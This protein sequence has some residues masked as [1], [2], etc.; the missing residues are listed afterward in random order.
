MNQKGNKQENITNIKG[1]WYVPVVPENINEK[2]KTKL[3]KRSNKKPDNMDSDNIMSGEEGNFFCCIEINDEKEE[4]DDYLASLISELYYIKSV[5]KYKQK[6]ELKEYNCI[7]KIQNNS[8]FESIL[9]KLNHIEQKHDDIVFIK[10]LYFKGVYYLNKLTDSPLQSNMIEVRKYIKFIHDYTQ[11]YFRD[12]NRNKDE[13]LYINMIIKEW[14]YIYI[15]L[16]EKGVEEVIKEDLRGSLFSNFSL[17]KKLL[18]NIWTMIFYVELES[19]RDNILGGI[20]DIRKDIW[21]HGVRAVDCILC[22]IQR[23]CLMCYNLSNGKYKEM[24]K[25]TERIR[26]FKRTL[27]KN[28]MLK[29]EYCARKAKRCYSQMWID[30]EATQYFALSGAPNKKNITKYYEIAE[31]LLNMNQTHSKYRPAFFVKEMRYYYKDRLDGYITYSE[32]E[33]KKQLKDINDRDINMMFSCC[34]RKLLIEIDKRKDYP[35]LQG[36]IVHICIKYEPCQIC[37]R[38]L[39][40]YAGAGVAF[41][42]IAPKSRKNQ[43]YE[44]ID[45]KIK[46]FLTIS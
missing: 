27:A 11:N 4:F 10:R 5:S 29:N 8:D 1:H 26:K 16:L 40:L 9:K 46:N 7:E 42:I 18:I 13:N 20:E 19:G 6:N 14:E 37:C 45:K 32:V 44:Q 33:G 22:E 35:K 36:K 12:Y 15:N 34:E 2:D 41:E 28:K 31:K 24:K 30:K 23:K 43:K 25:F 39:N 17:H 21:L 38:A 3:G